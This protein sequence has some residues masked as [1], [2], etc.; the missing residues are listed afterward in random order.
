MSINSKKENYNSIE[1]SGSTTPGGSMTMTQKEQFHAVEK[2]LL[3]KI[4]LRYR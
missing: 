4:D 1:D 3:R 2:R